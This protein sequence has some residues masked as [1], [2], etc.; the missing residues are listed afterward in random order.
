MT[1]VIY[2]LNGCQVFLSL[3]FCLVNAVC[4]ELRVVCNELDNVCVYDNIKFYFL[5]AMSVLDCSNKWLPSYLFNQN[6]HGC[7]MAATALLYL[8]AWLN[9]RNNN[10][11]SLNGLQWMSAASMFFSLVKHFWILYYHVLFFN[12]GCPNQTSPTDSAGPWCAVT[13]CTA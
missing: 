1:I 3:R 7:S 11:A 6:T 10:N 2:N 8:C 12:S 9:S 4:L 5:F 13:K